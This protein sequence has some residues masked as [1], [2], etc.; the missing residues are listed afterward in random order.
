MSVQALDIANE[1]AANGIEKQ[2]A[3]AIG[4][5]IVRS[6]EA[7]Q[8]SLAT[9]GGLELV[10]NEID[11]LR[12]ELLLAIERQRNGFAAIVIGGLGFFFALERFLT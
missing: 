10:R 5:A 3:E 12:A 1:L 2:Q 7:N 9:K 4:S 11:K 8:D 6:L